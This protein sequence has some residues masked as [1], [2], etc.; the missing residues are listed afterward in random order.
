MPSPFSSLPQAHPEPIFA[1]AA[2]A[3][4]AGPDAINGTIGIYMDEEG[5]P[6]LFTSVKQAMQEI[7][8]ELTEQS[9]G[10]PPILGLPEF[11]EVVTDLLFPKHDVIT[12]T[13]GTCG[14][15]G[16]LSNNLQL[17]KRM[18]ENCMMI[19]P[20]PAWANHRP[21][22][23][24]AGMNVKEVPYFD[25]GKPAI[26]EIITALEEHKGSC[27]M[28]LQAGCHNPSGLDLTH[29]Q[30]KELIPHFQESECIVLLDFAYQGFGDEPDADASPLHLLAENKIPLLIAWS[31]AKNHSIYSERPGLACAVVPDEETKEQVEMHYSN[32][33][34][35]NYSASPIFGQRIVALVQQKH[36]KQWLRDLEEAR[37][38]L[39]KK[40]ENL[41]K[42]TESYFQTLICLLNVECTW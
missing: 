18:Q 25:E 2:E 16:A 8:D 39:R 6:F 41:H 24:A 38:M 36:Q 12:A 33:T 30:W 15:T 5:K 19:L 37:L 31:G 32:L 22:L 27:S 42:L 11:R 13:M 10:Y 3:N 29:D 35:G 4:A 21:L 23:E 34:R 20:V 14:G 28:M 17:I 26:A 1:V 40:R 7:A 9:Y